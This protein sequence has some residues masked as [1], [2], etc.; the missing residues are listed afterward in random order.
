MSFNRRF[1]NSSS[2]SLGGYLGCP[3][4]P[5]SSFYPNMFQLGSSLPGGSRET[6]FEPTSYQNPFTVT[7]SCRTS[8]FRPE[9]FIF[10]GPC[11]TN[12]TGSLGF[13]NTSFGSFGYRNP[14]F[15][16]LGCGY[17]FC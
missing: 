6:I 10:R 2:R 8:R 16:S 17:N 4:S 11:Q 13:G 7:R 3:V 12:C 15:Q 1:G 5:Y 9:N 14:A